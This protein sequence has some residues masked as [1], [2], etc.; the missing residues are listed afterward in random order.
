MD[1]KE[2]L[3]QSRT[4]IKEHMHSFMDSKKEENLP[5]LFKE[6]GLI[7][8][9]E[10]FVMRGKLLRG[11]LFLFTLESFGKKIEEE[12]LDI[13]CAIELMHSA[14]LIQDDIIDKDYT[15]RGAKTI[16]AKYI[17][18]GEKVGAYDPYHYGVSTG[19]VAADIAF[20][21]AIDLISN[22]S[23]KSLHVLLKYYAHEVYLV[24]LAE[25]ADSLFGQTSKEPSMDE[26]YD[27]YKYKTAR[28]TFSLPFEMGA[29]VSEAS[30]EMRDSLNKL[31]EL[32]GIIFQLKDDE[33]GIFGSE[34][35][36]GKPIGNDIRE[37]KKTILRSY[38][39]KK[40]DDSDKKILDEC[41]GNE[42][43]GIEQ[44]NKVKSLYE[45]YHIGDMINEEIEKIM[46][47]VW[48]I[49]E[50]LQIDNEYKKILK[51]LLEF[52]LKRSA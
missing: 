46:Q 35:L 19:I 44:T 20:F 30:E 9:L 52:N 22:Y 28:Y 3:E 31:G 8:S 37:D 2:Y 38:L 47:K 15:R 51:G 4:R 32:V 49:Y 13:A 42:N 34:E 14:L 45:K 1:F 43:A 24:S 11:S 41:F 29:I 27:V 16:F 33:I 21:F 36:I 50:S 17:S 5:A 40:A 26:I 6:Q 25:S 18:E 48:P 23:S 39:Y 7:E 12:H 10:D